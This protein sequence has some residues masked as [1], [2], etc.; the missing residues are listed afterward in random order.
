LKF[1]NKEVLMPR[2]RRTTSR[3]L[4]VVLILTI[5]IST[6]CVLRRIMPAQG[7]PPALSAAPLP[8]LNVQAP[9]AIPIQA[10]PKIVTI[11]TAAPTSQPTVSQTAPPS[12]AWSNLLNDGSTTA[13]PSPDSKP[14][15]IVTGKGPLADGQ[16]RV[17]AGQLLEARSVLNDAL[18][19]GHLNS[20]DTDAARSLMQQIS[21]TLVF[22]TK[23]YA[24]D[25]YTASYSVRH[26]DSLAKIAA[27]FD[28][29]WQ[30]LARINHLDPRRL[31]YG[32]T[33]K[34]VKGPFFAVVR[35][36]A[37][38]LDAYLGALPG[39]AGSMYVTSFPVGLG[40]DNSTPTGLWAI[41]PHS[42]LK[43]PTYYPPEGGDAIDAD[44]PKNPLG[45][46]WIGLTG[47]DG[48]AVGAASY[49]IHG[50]IDPASIGH[51]SSMGCIRLRND[52]IA[53]VFDLMV[54][55]KSL[56]RVEQ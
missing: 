22:S 6:V 26:G 1:E 47:I 43:H 13:A 50:T 49:G 45:G 15:G 39:K 41:G 27:G 35:K 21:Q 51:Q 42:K 46:F 23:A 55:G 32:T 8:I 36:N 19:S 30:M 17:A 40:R 28:T 44:D 3:G 2:H 33:I 29:T 56:V 11:D 9:A 16:A 5:G 18:Q 25:A 4:I 12:G 54:E 37:Y 24:G 20:A 53:L 10:T 14:D 38:M 52:D 34:I 31:R 7:A 48:Q